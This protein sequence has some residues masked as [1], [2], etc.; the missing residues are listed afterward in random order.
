MDLLVGFSAPASVSRDMLKHFCT[1]LL[2]LFA[3]LYIR[4]VMTDG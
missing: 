1:L 4:Q 3:G 2:Q